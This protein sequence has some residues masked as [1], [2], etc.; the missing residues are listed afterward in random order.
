[1]TRTMRD[2]EVPTSLTLWLRR[3]TGR[4]ASLAHRYNA[5]IA[6]LRGCYHQVL[7]P[8]GHLPKL[9]NGLCRHS[10]ASVYLDPHLIWQAT[11]RYVKRCNAFGLVSH[12]GFRSLHHISLSQPSYNLFAS[13]ATVI[14]SR[15]LPG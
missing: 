4:H 12:P 14:A 6:R 1:M 7:R 5:F 8:R 11:E 10:D 3:D 15:N 13:A 2:S 9:A